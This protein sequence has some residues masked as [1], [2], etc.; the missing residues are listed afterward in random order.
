MYDGRVRRVVQLVLS[1]AALGVGVALLLDARL[2]SDGYSMMINGLSL[3]G[4]VEFLLV[5]V[6]VGVALVAMAWVRGRKPGLGTIT[7]PVV[8]GAVVSALL[9]VLPTPE[10]WTARS[11]EF[12]LAFVVLAIGVA[13][14]LA[15]DLGA[16]P[17][18]VAA[19]AWDPP[20][21]FRWS[22]TVVQVVGALI[23]WLCGATFGI[24]TFV[25]VLGLGWCV[26]RLIP[27]FPAT[28]PTRNCP[29]PLDV[30]DGEGR[31]H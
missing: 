10:S 11:V 2:G 4:D 30:S 17:T 7:Q 3:A 22:Y 28:L 18:E 26:D 1:C 25:V 13:G 6:V 15:A 24:G 16:G 20:V 23:G 5:N 27:L 9:P 29:S 21:P 14:Y 19:L 12:A 31:F 8:V